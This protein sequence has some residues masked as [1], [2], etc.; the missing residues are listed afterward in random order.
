MSGFGI[1]NDS[2]VLASDTGCQFLPAR[3]REPLRR[4]GRGYWIRKEFYFYLSGIEYPASVGLPGPY[5][6]GRAINVIFNL[7]NHGFEVKL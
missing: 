2:Y 3:H 4:G 7:L 5:R 6:P 1:A